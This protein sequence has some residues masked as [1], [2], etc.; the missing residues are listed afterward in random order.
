[1][2]TYN[3]DGSQS[4]IVTAVHVA[5]GWAEIPSQ[6]EVTFAPNGS[7][8]SFRITGN[9]HGRKLD[10]GLIT[11]PEAPAAVEGQA[12][13]PFDPVA[14]MKTA[15]FSAYEAQ[16]TASAESKEL[17]KRDLLNRMAG[18]EPVDVTA[19][20]AGLRYNLDLILDHG[21]ATGK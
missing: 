9:P 18:G 6:L 11:R 16:A 12:A 4:V 7:V 14:E 17:R 3:E 10:T 15:L 21:V 1:M 2:V 19:L 5:R 20:S 8:R 13:A